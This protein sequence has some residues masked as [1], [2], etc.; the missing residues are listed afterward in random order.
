MRDL[1]E[2]IQE[3]EQMEPSARKLASRIDRFEEKVTYLLGLIDNQPGFSSNKRAYLMREAETTSDFPA[4]FN[5]I[6][7]RQLM[8]MYQ[9]QKLDWRQYIKTG[10]QRDFKVANIIGVYGLQAVLGSVKERGEYVNRNLGDGKIPNSLAKYGAQFGLSWEDIINDDLGAFTDTAMRLS[11]AAARTEMLLA[12]KL[13]AQSSGPNTAL[14]GT[15]LSH[16]IDGKTIVNK[17]TLVLSA[18]NLFATITALQNQLDYD[19]Y[20]IVVDGFHLVVAPAKRKAALEAVSP[21]ALIAVGQGNA[22]ARQTSANVAADLDITIHVNSFLPLVDTT[23]GDTS[24]YVIA[25]VKNGTAAQMNFL[26]GHENP[27]VVMK[28]PNKSSVQGGMGSPMDGDFESDTLRWRVRHVLGGTPVD[29]RMAYAQ[30]A[31][32]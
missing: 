24:W 2:V 28:A 12:T 25:D 18:D 19:G 8:Q 13:I 1:L 16:P 10:T 20:P 21:A 23:H 27:E 5:Y 32:S 6:L 9:I 3:G 22:A 14:F 11:N 15:S 31:T 17:D 29:P 26:S 30:A 4:L 7:D